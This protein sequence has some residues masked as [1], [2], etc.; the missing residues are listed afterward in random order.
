MENTGESGRMSRQ[1]GFGMIDRR[2][3]A[4]FVTTVMGLHNNRPFLVTLSIAALFTT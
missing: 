4:S 2:S 3:V 1:A